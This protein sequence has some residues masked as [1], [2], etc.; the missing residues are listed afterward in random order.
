MNV[1]HLSHYETAISRALRAYELERAESLLA[2]YLEAA[3]TVPAPVDPVQS[4]R[5]RAGY[6]GAQVALAAGRLAQ[7]VERLVPV[8]E[9][10]AGLP[11]ELAS[12][13][14]L[15]AAEAHARRRADAE[16]RRCLAQVGALSPS[17]SEHRLLRLRQIRVRLWL[18]DLKQLAQELA[19][20]N[21]ELADDP[22]NR[23]LLLC[24]EGRAWDAVGELDPAVACWAQA[25][26]LDRDRVGGPVLADVLIQL[27]RA[28]HLRGRL[29]QALDHYEAA[30]ECAAGETPQP[31]E[32]RL[33]RLLVWLELNQWARARTDLTELRTRMPDPLPEELRALTATV[34]ALLGV[35]VPLV[36]GG[37]AR[38]Y[39]A[40]QRGDRR[41]ARALYQRAHD[42]EP[43]PARRARLALSL[44]QLDLLDTD[45]EGA[46]RWLECA[47]RLART[48]GLAEVLWRA[49]DAL[50]RV[51]AELDGDD[52]RAR[53]HFEEAVLVSE[54]QVRGLRRAK[55]AAG[56]GL[57]RSDLVRFL[58]RGACRRGDA[59]AVFHYQEL[60][61]GRLLLDL[62]RS[63]GKG[64]G[65]SPHLDSLDSRLQTCEAALAAQKELKARLD[66]TLKRRDQL[67]KRLLFSPAQAEATGRA[68]LA[69]L[70]DEA[71][72]LEQ[73][74]NAPA[75]PLAEV[76]RRLDALL[77][78]RDRALEEFFSDRGRPAGAALPRLPEL[79]DLAAVL[80]HGT[81]YVAP[82]IVEDKLHLLV[83]CRGKTAQL[84]HAEGGTVAELRADIRAL[85]ECIG[86]RLERF[87][88][89]MPLGLA[90]RDQLNGCLEGLGQ[91]LLGRALDRILVPGERLLWIPDGEL[92]GL[93]IH[94][95]RSR[96]GYLIERQEVVHSFSGALVVQ[97]HG[98]PR[99][100]R[101]G[102]SPVVVESPE[103]LPSAAE[104]GRGVRAALFRGRILAGAE[105]SKSAIRRRLARARVAHFACHAEFDANRPLAARLRL[106]SGESWHAVEWL[107]EPVAG[108]PLM[109]L[110]ACRSA[111]VKPLVGRE[112][113]GLV[114]AVL[115]AGVRAV[116]AGLWSVPDRH[117]AA[118]MWRFYGYRLTHDLGTA[119]A[120][121]QRDCLAEPGSSPLFWAV[122]AL[123]GDPAA[124]PAPPWW[125]R[126]WARWQQRRHAR[127]F[128]AHAQRRRNATVPA[129]TPLTPPAA[130]APVGAL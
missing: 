67:L 33:R 84:I 125:R 74:V 95:L 128:P 107:D 23:A 116:L 8:L 103:V 96:A 123:F 117:A 13:A 80:P 53:R 58:L 101:W 20:C 90:E 42:S 92:Q 68:K 115:G 19:A 55:D 30:L 122:F 108:L 31:S 36:E 27:G 22:S 112:V 64:P 34:E 87:T 121:A 97:Q 46:V 50:G 105:A 48:E 16:A 82:S 52:R 4:P 106:P 86:A 100:F 113:F 119:L 40:L 6:L 24:E 129:S 21:R 126:W 124:L 73:Q 76:A 28:D 59:A 99:S 26:A 29:Q 102:P 60:E 11:P 89:Q 78:E 118:L 94:A 114:T 130:K 5:L 98:A 1:A 9:K 61:R 66:D 47:E 38:A 39:T 65:L 120:L 15:L 109:T 69:H 110:S 81:V 32:I 91:G 2:D 41:L 79:A 83:V 17:W 43:A 85:W 70:Q 10:A 37:E 56:Y 25:Q 104:E 12:R 75:E 88:S 49:L 63:G 14:W 3:E 45:R 71:H 54:E 72:A 57:H 7:A 18:G 62:W 35:S 111:A 44:G 93:P 127:N 51:A 77:L